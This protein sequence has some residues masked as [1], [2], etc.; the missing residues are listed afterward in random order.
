MR[1]WFVLAAAAGLAAC[2]FVQDEKIDGPYRFVA[3]DSEREAGV[4][5]ALA[6]GS[7]IGRIPERVVAVAYNSDFVVGEVR[8]TPDVTSFYYVIRKVDG[9]QVDPSVSV[10]GPFDAIAFEAERSRL[11]LPEPKPI[12]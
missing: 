3:V 2:G 12:R 7:C 9:P 4:C 11:G 10:R 8:Q 1:Y 6:D 5:F